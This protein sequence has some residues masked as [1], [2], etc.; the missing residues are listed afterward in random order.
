MPTRTSSELRPANRVAY[1]YAVIRIVPRPELGEFINAGVILHCTERKF[2]GARIEFSERRLTYL[3][4]DADIGQLRENVEVIPRICAAATD[5]GPIAQLSARERFHWLT[6]PRSSSIQMSPV[7]CGICESP[8]VA[9]N[10]LFVKLAF[11]GDS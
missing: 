8:E 3:W 4:P 7:H 1:D 11:G 2:L 6:A 10:R 5:A 9:L